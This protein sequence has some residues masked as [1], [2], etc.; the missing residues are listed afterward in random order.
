MTG[1]RKTTSRHTPT[2]RHKEP[3]WGTLVDCGGHRPWRSD[4]GTSTGTHTH[5]HTYTNMQTKKETKKTMGRGEERRGEEK[6]EAELADDTVLCKMGR[7]GVGTCTIHS[8]PSH[9]SN[10]AWS[11]WFLFRFGNE[12]SYR[13]KR[14]DFFAMGFYT[15]QNGFISSSPHIGRVISITSI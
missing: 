13:G 1:T 4:T 5:T 3:L 11:T 7:L 9:H 8:T 10:T 6:R 12:R 15:N 14:F 2:Q